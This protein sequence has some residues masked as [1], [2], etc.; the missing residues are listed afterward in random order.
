MWT[1]KIEDVV[2]WPDITTVECKVCGLGMFVNPGE[3]ERCTY[4]FIREMN[5]DPPRKK[6]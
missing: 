1:I 5:G 6:E 4:C 2:P 3:S